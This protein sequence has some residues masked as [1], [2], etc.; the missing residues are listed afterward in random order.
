[1]RFIHAV[2]CLSGFFLLLCSISYPIYQ[3]LSHFLLVDILII[4]RIWLLWINWYKNSIHIFGGHMHSFLFYTYIGVEIFCHLWHRSATLLRKSGIHL[5]S[6]SYSGGHELV[7]YCDFNLHFPNVEQLYKGLL[8]IWVFLF[9]KC[10]LRFVAY[11]HL[12]IY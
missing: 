12:I 5:L 7:S 6:F 11:F 3:I 9:V 8:A 10:L 1:M 2:L 4:F